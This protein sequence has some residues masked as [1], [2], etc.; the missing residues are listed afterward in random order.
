MC[1]KESDFCHQQGGAFKRG[2]EDP[3]QG[4]RLLLKTK[5]PVVSAYSIVYIK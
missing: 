3:K 1:D 5:Q 4:L 2:I